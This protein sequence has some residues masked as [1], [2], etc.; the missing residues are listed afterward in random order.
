V[1]AW[2]QHFG[3]R[4]K[5]LYVIRLDGINAPSRPFANLWR[6]GAK[7]QLGN[8]CPRRAPLA[9]ASALQFVR[10][11]ACVEFLSLAKSPTQ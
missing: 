7:S 9:Q 11:N 10:D 5:R 1:V 4:A 8:I 6:H 2:Q 3:K